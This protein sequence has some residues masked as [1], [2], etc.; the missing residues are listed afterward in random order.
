M[1]TDDIQDIAACLV[2]IY[3]DEAQDNRLCEEAGRKMNGLGGHGTMEI[4]TELF[5]ALRGFVAVV[6]PVLFERDTLRA[7]DLLQELANVAATAA[8]RDV[9]AKAMK[10][11]DNG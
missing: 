3:R 6:K 9:I 11:D 7:A 2:A 10:G 1:K 8:T 5:V 4:P